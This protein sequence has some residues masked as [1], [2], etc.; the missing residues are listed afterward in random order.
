MQIMLPVALPYASST[1]A[2]V[3]PKYATPTVP[4]DSDTKVNTVPK[5]KSKK[6]FED[7]MKSNRPIAPLPTD[8]IEQMYKEKGPMENTVEHR[9]LEKMKGFAYRTLL[10]ELMYAYITCCPDIGY[11]VTTLSKFSTT[12][13][14]Y[15]YKLLKGVAKYLRSTIGWGICF[16]RSEPLD[17][18]NLQ[19]VDNYAIP[20]N[21]GFATACNTNQAKLFGFV[22]AAYANDH[23]KRRST[24]GIAFT[25]CGGTIVYKSKTQSLTAT[26]STEAEFLAAFTAGKICRYLRMVLKQL[27]YEQVDATIIHINNKATVTIINYN[28]SPTERTRYID[29]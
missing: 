19:P 16:H 23:R 27:G 18:P 2:P 22:D 6:I 4:V 8:C 1:S 12:P 20:D 9:V 5:S 13:S 26:S 15:H 17:H 24:T 21:N 3:M 7:C 14:A 29:V 11:A 25:F 10:G 28:T